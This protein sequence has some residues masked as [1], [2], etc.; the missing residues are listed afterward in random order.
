MSQIITQFFKRSN[1]SDQINP[2]LPL[3]VTAVLAIAILILSFCLEVLIQYKANIYHLAEISIVSITLSAWQLI[4]IILSKFIQH[5]SQ[6]K[7]IR[8]LL[9][10]QGGILLL[11][12]GIL[13]IQSSSWTENPYDFGSDAILISL[14][15]S[16]C[17]IAHFV[18]LN[19][20][21]LGFFS[22]SEK[23]AQEQ[24]LIAK[25]TESKLRERE[26][27]IHELHDGFGSQLVAARVHAQREG[28]SQDETVKIF[29]ECIADLHLI[30][31][32][33]KDDVLSLHDALVDL[34]FRLDR[35]LQSSAVKLSVNLDVKTI[36]PLSQE[37]IIQI[38][39]I[40]QEAISNAIQH[41]GA[42]EVA[43]NAVYSNQ[44]LLVAI[45]DNGKGFNLSNQLSGNGVRN[46]RRRAHEIGA[47][48]D[49]KS[50][51]G[52]CVELRL[53]I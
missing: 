23:V 40:V 37:A 31:D 8:G 48:F 24:A 35:R 45:S 21:I 53:K 1:K 38:L 10:L 46:M 27:L 47:Q 19:L 41:S 50:G 28:L 17:Y 4:E 14:V 9:I 3:I 13:L 29:N 43:L 34:R 33:M 16:A 39:R 22:A 12:G 5:K 30:V 52:A 2:S 11:R 25:T 26:R 51:H 20:L 15:F 7:I 18:G 49:L 6:I 42:T 32:V 44:Q 36:P